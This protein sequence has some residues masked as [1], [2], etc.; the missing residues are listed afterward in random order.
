MELYGELDR[1]VDQ[2]KIIAELDCIKFCHKCC[3][4]EGRKIEVSAFE[5]L[6]LSIHLWQTEKAEFYLQRIAEAGIRDPC[7]LHDA[8]RFRPD[9]W[10]CPY[11]S[12]RPLI[13]RL[14]G[15][16]AILD[17]HGVKKVA[18]CRVIKEADPDAERRTNRSIAQGLKAPVLSHLA[19]KAFFLNPNAGQRRYP[20]N[21]G[22]KI[23]LEKVG[24]GLEL[25]RKTKGSK[26]SP[27]SKRNDYGNQ[28]QKREDP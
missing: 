1:E 2:F 5:C 6:P 13:C 14:F 11:Y 23:A 18:L 27:A 20:M 21:E 12:W 7:V 17:K 24:F 16:S 10:G 26:E 19:R 3:S 28:S 25:I 15:F 4:T 22:L 8:D 9:G